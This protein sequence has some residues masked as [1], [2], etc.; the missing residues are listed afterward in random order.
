M[1]K[2]WQ[3]KE[4]QDA[5]PAVNKYII[6]QNLEADNKLL[7]FDVE[8]SI[9]HAE[10]LKQSKLIDAKEADQIIAQ[11]RRIIELHA[12]GDF[13]LQQQHEDVHTEIENFLVRE[14]G[15]TGK[16]IHLGRSRNDQV[17]VAMRLYCRDQIRKT[18]S[19]LLALAQTILRFASTHEFVAMPGFT[20]MQHAMPSSVGQWA[21]AFV[22]SCINDFDILESAFAI[23]D[24][25][26]LGSAAGFGTAVP[27]DRELTTR[28]LGFSK[29][30]I[31]T[32]FCQ[33]SR[34]KFDAYTAG[35][36]LQVMLTLGKIAN[37][38]VIF[39][40]YE[41][42]FFDV[43]SQLTTGSS[44]MP[45]KR[46]LDLME[47]LRANV[48]VVQSLQFQIQTVGQNLISGYNKDIK[49]VK[50]AL[51]D[52]F[53]IVTDSLD[54]TGLLFNHLTPNQAGLARAF[55]DLEIFATDAANELVSS[56]MPFREAY[57]QVGQ[58]LSQLQKQD[59]T[60]NLKSKKHL[61]APG[62][63][64]LERYEQEIAK[65]SGGAR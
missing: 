17:L 61:G 11:L 65:R 59:V 1:S 25:N 31:N 64:G 33:N 38:V 19:Q 26:P 56:G 15:D 41:F 18:Q 8:A 63:L 9:A 53:T 45:Q 22:E 5:H 46:N 42:R 37:D 21:A 62:N 35:C 51:I 29:P 30:Q 10:M 14:L 52:C 34:A 49:I 40:S 4:G 27:I 47:V 43:D 13:V 16:R 28:L 55:E 36:L 48:S 57:R 44:I 3:K 20:H 7:R 12:K 23:N 2:L 39:N 50:K 60:L 32:I 24:Q 6:S 58:N 54:V